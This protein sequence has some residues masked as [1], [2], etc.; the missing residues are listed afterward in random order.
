[1]RIEAGLFAKT[2]LKTE[3]LYPYMNVL[4]LSAIVYYMIY[5]YVYMQPRD[6]RV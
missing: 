5:T 4:A 6:L 3:Y 2:R 1:M